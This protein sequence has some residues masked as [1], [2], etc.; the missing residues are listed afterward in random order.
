MKHSLFVVFTIIVISLTSSSCPTHPVYMDARLDGPL[1][2]VP[3]SFYM[4]RSKEYRFASVNFNFG[5]EM[6]VSLPLVET[7]KVDMGGKTLLDEDLDQDSLTKSD[8]LY[9]KSIE[10]ADGTYILPTKDSLR[11]IA[12][13]H[14]LHGLYKI[15]FLRSNV[16]RKNTISCVCQMIRHTSFARSSSLVGALMAIYLKIGRNEKKTKEYD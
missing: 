10:D 1:N 12:P 14:P 11:I 16:M 4:E 15:T 13:S 7:D 9:R 8:S 6:S 2:I 3:D 5:D